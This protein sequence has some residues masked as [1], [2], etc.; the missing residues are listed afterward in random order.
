MKTKNANLSVFSSPRTY[1]LRKKSIS[2]AKTPPK[3]SL[4][5]LFLKNLDQQDKV[6][7][8]NLPKKKEVEAKISSLVKPL[9]GKT[10]RGH[11]FGGF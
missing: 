10:L 6:L 3:K 5:N 8:K 9:K 11:W 7:V 2:K 4:K 1:N